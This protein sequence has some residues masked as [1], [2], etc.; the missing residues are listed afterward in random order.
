MASSL[1]L[2]QASQS[3][4]SNL[5]SGRQYDGKAA[6]SGTLVPMGLCDDMLDRDWLRR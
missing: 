5:E 1:V 2:K 4:P 3:L 6:R